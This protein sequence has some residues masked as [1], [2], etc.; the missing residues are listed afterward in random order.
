MVGGNSKMS[1]HK[2][3]K[4]SVQLLHQVVEG[5]KLFAFSTAAGVPGPCD[6]KMD[7]TSCG[8]GC[9]CRGGQPWYSLNTIKKMGITLDK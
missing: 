7:G 1:S 2:K 9:M 8:A 3:V 4:G 6:G 5:K